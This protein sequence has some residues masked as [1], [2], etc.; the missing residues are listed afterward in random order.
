MAGVNIDDLD[1]VRGRPLRWWR[2][3]YQKPYT[4]MKE[5]GILLKDMSSWSR[6]GGERNRGIALGS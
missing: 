5:I 1:M 2:L 3:P 4:M 6:E